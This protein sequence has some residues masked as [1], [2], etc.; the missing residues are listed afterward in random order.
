MSGSANISPVFGL[1]GNV[2][3]EAAL[4]AIA[5]TMHFLERRDIPFLIENDVLTALERSSSDGTALWRG[6]E[7]PEI[8]AEADFVITFGGDGTML[9]VIQHTLLHDT[10]VL[11]VNLGKL[12][13]LADVGV[14]EVYW[15]IEEILERKHT[16]EKRMTISGRFDD[17]PEEHYAL[18]DIVL[19][20]SGAAK[21]I[22]IDAFVG[23]EF[24]ASF[25]ADGL[26]VST[27]TGSTAYSL[28]TGGPVVVPESN[29]IIISPISAHTLTARPVIVSGDSRIAVCARAEEGAVM[30]MAD[31]RVIAQDRPAIDAEIRRGVH[32]VPLVK[33]LGPKYFETLRR[34]LSWA[35]DGRSSAETPRTAGT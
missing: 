29:V 17:A 1:M 8:A 27:P 3:K 26:I 34:K 9:A 12:G 30:V 22:S 11:G 7:R 6:A 28:A 19:A 32:A 16:I 5:G 24:L 15:A 4:D 35:Q 14:D 2:G 21:V 20:K 18:N 31:G 25:L 23:E 33:N 10:P 13:F